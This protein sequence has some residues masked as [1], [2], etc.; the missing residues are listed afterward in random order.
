[1]NVIRTIEINGVGLISF[2]RSKRA[3]R[4]IISVKPFRG[5][6]VAVP[7]SSSFNKAE[8]FVRTKTV[9][10]KRHL[11]KIK[12]LE[13]KYSENVGIVDN[14][15]R[16]KARITLTKRARLLADKC[17]FSYNRV[18]IRNQKTRWG[19]CSS[20]NNISLNMKLVIL[21]GELVDYVILHELVHTRR[22][23]HSKAFWIELEKLMANSK[24]IRSRL[25]Q[26]GME[27]Y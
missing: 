9:W 16:A 8:A 2:E 24:Q 11:E 26:Y 13:K 14:I 5:I 6:R 10:I 17:G 12:Q 4:I 19:S 23:N 7:Y 27:L 18:F 21:P 22:K 25:K 1:M 15:D 3:K 20:K